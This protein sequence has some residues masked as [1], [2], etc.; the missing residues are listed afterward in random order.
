MV[1]KEVLLTQRPAYNRPTK[2]AIFQG[3][4]LT[5]TPLCLKAKKAALKY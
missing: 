4:E 2:K 3:V 5:A 1:K